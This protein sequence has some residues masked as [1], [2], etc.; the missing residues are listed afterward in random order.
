M[1][2]RFSF[3]LIYLLFNIFS[4][5]SA[6][7][8][9]FTV[10]IDPGHG[11]KDPG[12]VGNN[13]QEKYINLKV[14]LA[15]GNLIEKNMPDVKV[16]Y[17]RKTD[18]YVSLRDRTLIA[19][20]ANGDLFICIHTNSAN[21]SAYGA[22][23][24][25]IGLSKTN[26]NFEVAKRENSVILLDKDT[27]LYQGFNPESPDSYIM[28]QFMQSEYI[29]KSIEFAD[30]I[31]QELSEAKRH[32]RG[33][34]QAPFW[35]LHQVKMPSIL[36]ELGF[37]TN[38]TEAQFLLSDKG[39]KIMG[40]AIYDAFSKYKHEYDKRVITNDDAIVNRSK[41]KNEDATNNQK[42]SDIDQIKDTDTQT[43][44]TPSDRQKNTT[45]E[46]S[47]SSKTVSN[48]KDTKYQNS[49]S[50]DKIIFKLQTMST[51]SRLKQGGYQYK[52][53]DKY[54]PVN[55]AKNGDWYVYTCGETDSYDKI[56]QTQQEVKKYFK[57]AFIVAFQSGHRI[58]MPKNPK[59]INKKE[60]RKNL[61][62]SKNEND[63]IYKVQF[64]FITKKLNK[65]TT[66]YREITKYAPIEYTKIG[67][68]YK[69]T[70][71]KTSDYEK[72]RDILKKTQKYYK[73][74]Y[75]ITENGSK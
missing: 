55:F 65:N 24:Y 26:A 41:N 58:S 13:G 21:F 9:P 1:S 52:L 3:I 71:G 63:I 40:Q 44:M 73:D 61:Q 45:D 31:Q 33:V 62:N 38:R 5:F 49:S 70:C 6:N 74:A 19:N 35:V 29:D 30:Y 23:T 25:T 66:S 50:N 60:T 56:K 11:G 37:I 39:E 15:L 69:Y 42:D 48:K 68:N 53:M 64:C 28:F 34:R 14:A 54:P 7:L 27:T 51:K 16:V 22:E 10:I 4:A 32:N 46:E 17:T 72:I 59:E 12:A 36:V 2:K 18:K 43:V 8:K 57:G 20:R 75:I 47:A 67:N